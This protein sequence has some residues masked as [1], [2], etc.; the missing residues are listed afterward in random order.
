ML[1]HT[2][3]SGHLSCSIFPLYY[4]VLI[5]FSIRIYSVICPLTGIHNIQMSSFLYAMS[6][7]I[8]RILKHIYYVSK[9]RCSYTQC[10]HTYGVVLDSIPSLCLFSS[11]S[12]SVS[13]PPAVAVAC[14]TCNMFDNIGILCVMSGD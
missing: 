1:V 10:R 13:S 7:Y 3:N 2:V 9:F 4:S 8:W 12:H 14:I 5:P 6:S 11:V